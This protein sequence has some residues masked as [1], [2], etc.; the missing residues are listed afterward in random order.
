MSKND[1]F[2]VDGWMNALVGLGKTFDKDKHTYYGTYNPLSKQ[3]LSNI[4][5]GGGYSRKVV[6]EK[7]D[8]MTREWITIQ[9]DED[10]EIN[11]HLERLKAESVFN[12][13]I[14]WMK[15]YG[16]SIIIMGILDGQD[17]DKPLNINNK[18]NKISWLKPVSSSNIWLNY[19]TFVKDPKDPNFGKVKIFNCYVGPEQKELKVHHS[20]VLEFHGLP[21][22]EDIG[23]SNIELRYWGGS[24]LESVYDNLKRYCGISASIANILYEFCIGKYVIKGLTEK[25]AEGN[26]NQLITRMEIIQMYKSVLNAVILDEGESFTSESKSVAGLPELI[27]RVMMDLSGASGYPVTKLFGRSPAGE[28]AT[29]KSDERNYYDRVK[30][31]QKEKLKDPLQEL[32]NL[33]DKTYDISGDTHLIEFNPLFQLTEKEQAE[34]DKINGETDHIYIQD[35]VLDASEVRIMRFPELPQLPDIPDET[36]MIKKEETTIEKKDGFLSKFFKGKRK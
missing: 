2:N 8:D 30:S 5:M 4:Y 16:G 7:C 27:D 18:N 36:T 29:G 20:R 23:N 14:K 21:V 24:F 1:K 19:S 25:L 9:D 34:V 32:V 12:V 10:E 6:D 26:E 28:N 22:P 13:A 33:I 3:E 11:G 35:G 31:E 17:F 15:L